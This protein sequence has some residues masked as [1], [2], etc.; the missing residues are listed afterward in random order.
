MLV[1]ETRVVLIPPRREELS[2]DSPDER[3]ILR[4]HGRG[5]RESVLLPQ[6]T[7]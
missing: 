5:V 4:G 1:D 6:R 3:K 2:S 7:L